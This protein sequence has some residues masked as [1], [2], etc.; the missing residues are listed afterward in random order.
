MPC[1]RHACY[2]PVSRHSVICECACLLEMS[3]QYDYITEAYFFEQTPL[4]VYASY[5]LFL[6]YFYDFK[7][8]MNVAKKYL[9]PQLASYD[10]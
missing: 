3:S 2:V 9:Y 7:L 4:V 6:D 1:E 8:V 10:A 5:Y